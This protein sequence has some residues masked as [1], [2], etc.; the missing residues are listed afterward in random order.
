MTATQAN[1]A[2]EINANADR[3]HHGVTDELS[4]TI[5]TGKSWVSVK[6][7]VNAK[8]KSFHPKMRQ[9]IPA[10]TRPGTEFGRMTRKNAPIGLQPSVIAISS[11]YFGIP[12][13][14]SVMTQ[15]AIGS[16]SAT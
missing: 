5:E 7:R 3:D 2:T 1:G 13:K 15:T 4:D 11:S 6:V 14:K 10:T 16:S 9:N 8:K 12:A